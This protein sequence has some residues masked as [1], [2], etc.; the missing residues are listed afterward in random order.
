[1]RFQIRTRVVEISLYIKYYK[2][3]FNALLNKDGGRGNS[4]YIMYYKVKIN[5]LSYKDGGSGKLIV[6]K[7]P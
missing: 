3:K 6:N 2:V 1:M 5:A 7:V 4:L